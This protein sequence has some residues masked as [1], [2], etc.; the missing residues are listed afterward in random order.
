MILKI[1]QCLE[2]Y[3]PLLSSWALEE[4]VLKAFKDVDT[5]PTI[6]QLT[7]L[8]GLLADQCQLILDNLIGDATRQEEAQSK[9]RSRKKADITL[10]IEDVVLEGDKKK[11]TETRKKNKGTSD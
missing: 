5:E 7:E 1:F 4:A 3:L 8:L 11:K 10:S 2:I 6:T 9:R